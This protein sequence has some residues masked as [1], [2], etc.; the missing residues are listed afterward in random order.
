MLPDS[1]V[2]H[3]EATVSIG[4]KNVLGVGTSILHFFGITRKGRCQ[5]PERNPIYNITVNRNRCASGSV[6]LSP[7][8]PL[9]KYYLSRT[10][11]NSGFKMF[12]IQVPTWRQNAFVVSCCVSNNNFGLFQTTHTNKPFG[13]FWHH[14]EIK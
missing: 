1:P 10:N 2:V 11:E 13:T 9:H 4:L 14:P 12:S 8:F 7:S 5:C 6:Q 3:T